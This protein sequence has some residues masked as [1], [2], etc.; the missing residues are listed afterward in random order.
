MKSKFFIIVLIF[1]LFTAESLKSQ[2]IKSNAKAVKITTSEYKRGLPPNLFAELNYN[3][4]NNNGILECEEKSTLE[5]KILNK[6][7]GRAQGLTVSVTDD[8]Q[9]KNLIIQ[10]KIK[11]PRIEPNESF[12]VII[13]IKTRFDI[14]TNKHKLKI[15]VTEY[16]GYDMDPAYLKLSTLEY[17][18]PKLHFSG[19]EI[20]DSGDDAMPIIPDKQVQRGEMVKVKLIIQNIGT[21]VSENTKINIYCNNEDIYLQNTQQ[22][23]GNIKVGEVKEIWFTLSPN[24][25]VERDIIQLPIF[26]DA[27]EKKGKG[28]IHSMQLP[29]SFGQKPDNP[30]I[31]EVD[32]DFESI[33]RE[34]AVFEFESNKFI[35]NT[36]E[37]TD[38]KKIEPNNFTIPN[39]VGVVIGVENYDF[40]PNA[41][42]ADNDAELMK[43][44][45]EKILGVEQ[46]IIF[47]SEDVRGY[48]FDDIF[49]PTNGELQKAVVKGKTD[50]FIFYS[51]HGVPDKES[52]KAY[53]FPAD[54]RVHRVAQQGLLINDFY[55]NLLIA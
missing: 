11:I 4:N 16:F 31:L 17:Q 34:V 21:N 45:F 52:N 42:Y 15:D 13:P 29:I 41:P 14:K 54:G 43:E 39:S 23:L 19:L 37:Y 55:N 40:L 8:L 48:I 2:E 9:D 47:K 38:I 1:L 5:I 35:V 18:K 49:N 26:L 46:V 32:A 20:F 12:S 36:G 6:G 50:I 3:D 30:N 44:Y 28:G 33:S 25:R 7:K 51:G 53:L 10:D 24:K 22:E 27:T